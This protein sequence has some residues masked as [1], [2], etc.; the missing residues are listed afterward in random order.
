MNRRTVVAWDGS[1]PSETA[2]DWAA[3]REAFGGGH[4][5]LS[6]VVTE[7]AAERD[8]LNA[9]GMSE[10]AR[11]R[12]EDR[13]ERLRQA[14]P[15]LYV[16][17][18]FSW[19]DPYEELLTQSALAVLL[20][21]G[22][23]RRGKGAVR[24]GWSLGTRLAATASCPVAVVPEGAAPSDDR[25]V[26]GVDDD[27]GVSAAAARFAAMAAER[28]G[29]DLHVVHAWTEPP[30]SEAA[31]LPDERFLDSLRDEHGRILQDAIDPLIADFPSLRI[32]SDLVHRWPAWALVEQG[33]GAA[34]LVVGRRG[35]D[36]G[37][38]F[39]LGSISHAVVINTA[40][41]TVVV[42]RRAHHE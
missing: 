39:L 42:G 33:R 1:A 13:A 30:A 35:F 21:V 17:T 40:S 38:R 37:Q 41:P 26:V 12:L 36:K 9:D 4:L 8:R 3:E 20:V 14:H 31:H 16:T 19:G 2:L 18:E 27:V 22:T 24:Y 5:I 23:R 15:G 34:L 25:V 6:T 32:R 7:W 11:T 10:A 28:R 29:S